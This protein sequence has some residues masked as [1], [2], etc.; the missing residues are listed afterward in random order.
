MK[1]LI[2]L[3]DKIILGLAALAGAGFAAVTLAIVVDVVLRN[4]GMR[5]FQAT[6]ALVEYSLLFAAM[7]AG[8]WLIREGGHVVVDSFVGM[9]PHRLQR[10]LGQCAMLLSIAVLAL[11]SWRAAL[12]AVDAIKFGSTDMRSIN[13]PYWIAYTMLSIG[14]GLMAT[15][16]LR[17]RLIGK[18]AF[19]SNVN[20]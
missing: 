1:A 4:F 14:F 15:E 17:L 10:V 18:T 6:S 8:P 7:A 19:S 11:L 12:G 13:I 2:H 16:V 5:P 3:Y 20:H 9:A